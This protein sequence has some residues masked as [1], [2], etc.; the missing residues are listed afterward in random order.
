MSILLIKKKHFLERRSLKSEYINR[1]SP[2]I[3][4]QPQPR[5]EADVQTHIFSYF[6]VYRSFLLS[7]CWLTCRIKR[8][9]LTTS[10]V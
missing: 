2:H 8:T 3:V 10:H 7:R 4:A 5:E 1:E 9:D 6:F